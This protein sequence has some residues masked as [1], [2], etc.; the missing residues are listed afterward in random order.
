MSGR[1]E[2]AI[3]AAV[4]RGD[5]DQYRVLVERHHAMLHGLMVR[6]LADPVLAADIVHEAFVRAYAGLEGF[7]GRSS[8]STWLVQ[9]GINLA[10]DE[11]RRRRRRPP[12]VS[13]D[14][15]LED[16]GHCAE[17]ADEARQ[18]DPLDCM[19]RQESDRLLLSALARLPLQ[20]RE[21]LTLRYFNDWSFA[22]IADV[23]GESVG[24]LKVRAHRARLML[25]DQMIRD[26]KRSQL[27]AAAPAEPRPAPRQ[28]EP[29]A[30]RDGH[31][32]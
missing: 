27:R 21:V 9:I 7:R 18:N 5:R 29:A 3:I 28:A 31:E 24:T 17:P 6:L 19:C 10:R 8:F 32:T 22:E 23:T 1:D 13:L 2:Q 26:E 12:T 16:L 14:Q 25:R 4:L 30:R 20:Y 15:R 11:L